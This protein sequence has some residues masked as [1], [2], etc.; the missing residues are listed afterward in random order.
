MI[1]S[2]VTRMLSPCSQGKVMLLGA[3]GDESGWQ[4]ME[5][6]SAQHSH[7]LGMGLVGLSPRP[8]LLEGMCYPRLQPEQRCVPKAACSQKEAQ[9]HG[10]SSQPR[11]R[12]LPKGNH[13]QQACT[14]RWGASQGHMATCIP[15][16]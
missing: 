9:G 5:H 11:G 3:S 8:L 7:R 4:S 1:P 15:V 10:V 2:P 6:P 16:W 12:G 14:Q 13:L